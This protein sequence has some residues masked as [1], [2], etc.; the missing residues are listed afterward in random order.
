[1]TNNNIQQELHM[2]RE[3]VA[4]TINDLCIIIERTNLENQLNEYKLLIQY[5]DKLNNESIISIYEIDRAITLAK[6][7]CSIL[8]YS[9]RFEHFMWIKKGK[10]AIPLMTQI[11]SYI[12]RVESTL[13]RFA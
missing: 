10:C 11:N 7:T 12:T 9:P 5:I 2:L 13:H 8:K 1:M 3:Q 4:L 6:K